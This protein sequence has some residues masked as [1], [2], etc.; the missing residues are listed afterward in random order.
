[1]WQG[2]AEQVSAQVL[3]AS[4]THCP[5]AQVPEQ[6]PVS[7][8]TSHGGGRLAG[9]VA[10]A[11]AAASAGPIPRKRHL[12]AAVV[13]LA[14]RVAGRRSTGESAAVARRA[15]A[16]SIVTAPDDRTTGG[17]QHEREGGHRDRLQSACRGETGPVRSS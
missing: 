16:G 13:T 15:G 5:L 2:D 3:P 1:M 10:R 11:S 12:A 7:V 9:K 6:L 14:G 17:G 8:R 4:Q